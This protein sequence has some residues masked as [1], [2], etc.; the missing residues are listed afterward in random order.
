MREGVRRKANKI[1]LT[2]EKT[3]AT[4]RK[5]VPPPT[6]KFIIRF[7]TG[8]GADIPIS[9]PLHSVAVTLGRYAI[10]QF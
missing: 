4:I 5:S 8:R 6:S 3:N 7:H 9:N 2:K 1:T 10:L